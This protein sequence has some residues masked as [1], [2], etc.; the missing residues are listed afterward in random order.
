LRIHATPGTKQSKITGTS[1]FFL[2]LKFLG[3]DENEIYVALA[4][5]PVDGQAN[6]ELIDFMASALGLRKTEIEF[7][8]GATSRSKLIVIKSMRIN[9]DDVKK[10]IE[11]QINS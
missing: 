9:V 2:Y 4:A 8:K 5:K 3:I 7:K 10:R 11:E 6:K 1:I